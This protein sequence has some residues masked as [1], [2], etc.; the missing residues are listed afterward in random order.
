MKTFSGLHGWHSLCPYSHDSPVKDSM[1]CVGGLEFSMCFSKSNDLDLILKAARAT[2]WNL[3]S[4]ESRW[5]EDDVTNFDVNEVDYVTV[6]VTVTNAWLPKSELMLHGRT[7]IDKNAS[8]YVRYKFFDHDSVVSSLCPLVSKQPHCIDARFENLISAR[9]AHKK[10]FICKKSRPLRWYMRE[11]KMELQVWLTHSTLTK[12]S[13]PLDGDVLLGSCGVEFDSMSEWEKEQHISGSFNIFKAG[14]ENLGCG[15]VRAY[16]SMKPGQAADPIPDNTLEYAR[17]ENDI[18]KI[19]PD[20]EE[21]SQVK[22]NDNTFHATVTVERACHLPLVGDLE[23]DELIRPN[24]FVSFDAVDKN[25]SNETRDNIKMITMT[26]RIV[27]ASDN[28]VWNDPKEVTLPRTLLAGTQGALLLKV[29]HRDRLYLPEPDTKNLAQSGLLATDRMLG[30]ATMDSTVL[31]A[32]LRHVNGWYN[33]LDIHGQCLGQ[34]KVAVT[35]IRYN[36]LSNP[37]SARSNDPANIFPLSAPAPLVSLPPNFLHKVLFDVPVQTPS[38]SMYIPGVQGSME[39]TKPIGTPCPDAYNAKFRSDFAAVK[40]V[41]NVATTSMFRYATSDRQQANLV[42]TL[43]KQI[44]ELEGIKQ[45]FEERKRAR[46]YDSNKIY[47]SME[48]PLSENGTRDGKFCDETFRQITNPENARSVSHDG[49]SPKSVSKRK[50]SSDDRKKSVSNS[51]HSNS[52]TPDFGKHPEAASTKPTS[53]S[54]YQLQKDPEFHDKRLTDNEANSDIEFV[55][56]QSL[57]QSFSAEFQ[58]ETQDR[59]IEKPP[60][61]EKQQQSTITNPQSPAKL[62]EP[63]ATVTPIRSE[64]RSNL[65]DTS[66]W[67]TGSTLRVSGFS[68]D[69]EVAVGKDLDNDSHTTSTP[70]GSTPVTPMNQASEN[71]GGKFDKCQVDTV[72]SDVES[73]SSLSDDLSDSRSHSSPK[74]D[75]TQPGIHENVN[76]ITDENFENSSA[77]FFG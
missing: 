54:L 47:S 57:N 15:Q 5:L 30:F 50:N 31:R 36:I 17:P 67:L 55:Q 13:R 21:P 11:E 44:K 38:G 3:P 66:L 22:E 24:V 8:V 10:S 39:E 76:K 7:S 53:T 72:P 14:N 25:Y 26:T 63:L 9:I 59:I 68:S 40:S 1:P 18:S 64:M 49:F 74:V 41:P 12:T 73:G 34:L 19:S 56:P 42:D 58:Q 29:W 70:D 20:A 71:L 2:K 27:T 37:N 35:P 75:E 62:P 51:T 45:K 52:S 4:F 23:T 77:N 48:Y 69:D 28:A 46:F 6:S 33:V 61:I 65:D 32:G 16:V 43:Q 60:H